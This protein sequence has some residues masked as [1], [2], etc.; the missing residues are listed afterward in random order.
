M[1]KMDKMD[2]CEN[3]AKLRLNA[4]TWIHY[5]DSELYISSNFI[6][7][8]DIIKVRDYLSMLLEEEK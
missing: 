6:A 7:K 2:K 3:L 4:G 5:S 8:E 1:T